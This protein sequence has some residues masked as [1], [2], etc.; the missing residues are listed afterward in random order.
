MKEVVVGTGN[1]GYSINNQNVNDDKTGTAPANPNVSGRG[2]GMREVREISFSDTFSDKLDP[3][4]YPELL[5]QVDKTQKS[6]ADK[7]K[8]TL[9]EKSECESPIII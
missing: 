1:C 3:T 8:V 7:D 4:T 6:Y 5:R 9:G 2:E